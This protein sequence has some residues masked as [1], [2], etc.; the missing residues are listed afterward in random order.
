MDRTETHIYTRETVFVKGCF[1]KASRKALH[2]SVRHS[3]ERSQGREYIIKK[4]NILKGEYPQSWSFSVKRY[5]H[6]S[7]KRC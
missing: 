7:S 6:A 4:E 3:T 5:F 1:T 2:N